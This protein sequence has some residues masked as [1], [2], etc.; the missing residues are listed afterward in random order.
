[1]VN[2]ILWTAKVEIPA[3]GATCDVTPDDL[4]ANLDPK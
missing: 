3:G 2:A 1:V 4:K